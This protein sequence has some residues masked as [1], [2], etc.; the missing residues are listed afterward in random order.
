MKGTI[1]KHPAALFGLAALCAALPSAAAPD[2][3]D[4]LVVNGKSAAADIRTIGGSPY[5]KLAD[6]AKALGII[7][8]KRRI[9]MTTSWRAEWAL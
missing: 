6:V 1:M 9:K 2:A 3:A 4:T 5:V 8:T 7:V